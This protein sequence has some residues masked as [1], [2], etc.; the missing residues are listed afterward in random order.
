MPRNCRRLKPPAKRRVGDSAVP[1][2]I[3]RASLAQVMGECGLYSHGPGRNRHWAG[4]PR[5]SAAD[6]DGSSRVLYT[7]HTTPS[8]RRHFMS[9]FKPSRAAVALLLLGGLAGVMAAGAAGAATSDNDPPSIVVKY[10]DL[11]LATD[12]G[13]NQLYR[14]IV[15]A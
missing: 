7:R 9:T 15:S 11:S 5:R 8:P 14:R 10:S 12:S 4:R 3:M 6:S 1:R 2:S 13:V